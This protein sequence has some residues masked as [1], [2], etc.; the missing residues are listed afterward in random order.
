MSLSRMNAEEKAVYFIGQAIL[1]QLEKAPRDPDPLREIEAVSR[2]MEHW[3]TPDEYHHVMLTTGYDFGGHFERADE[4]DR[5]A[6][7]AQPKK[8]GFTDDDIPF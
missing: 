7:E 4:A 3:L 8:D 5:A 2:W 6:W 1:R